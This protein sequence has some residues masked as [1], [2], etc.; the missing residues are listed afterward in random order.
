MNA[1]GK[2]L[3]AYQARLV[4]DVSRASGDVL[5]SVCGELWRT[6]GTAAGTSLAARSASIVTIRP[7]CEAVHLGVM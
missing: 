4:A 2:V 5:V 7:A 6:D 1:V 3:R